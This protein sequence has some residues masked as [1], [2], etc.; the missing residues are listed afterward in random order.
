M[1]KL[2]DAVLMRRRHVLDYFGISDEI[3][4]KWELAGVISRVKG[5][6]RMRAHYLRSQVEELARR[7]SEGVTL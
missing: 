3:L 5:A 4:K 6:G 1:A 7:M 2:P